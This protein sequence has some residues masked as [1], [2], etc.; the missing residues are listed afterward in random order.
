MVVD[1]GWWGLFGLG[2]WLVKI[3]VVVKKVVELVMFILLLLLEE[4][5]LV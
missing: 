5:V 1:F 2:V 4:V 3:E